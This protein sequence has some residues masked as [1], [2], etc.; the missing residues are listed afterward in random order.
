VKKQHK[1]LIGVVIGALVLGGI[2]GGAAL[3]APR[4]NALAGN[5][6]AA[7]YA[8]WGCP[9]LNGDY[10]TV[11]ALLGM[12]PEQIR[13]ELQQGK[14]LVEMA[15]AKGITEDQLVT[16]ILE[17]MKQFME[18]QVTAG[19]WT[20]AQKQAHLEQ[21]EEHVRQTVEAKGGAANGYANGF[22]C[23]GGMMGG[24]GNGGAG[25]GTFR[26]GMMGR[27]Y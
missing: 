15:T 11:A 1:I 18:Q 12:T 25:T 7:D 6:T 9:M 10:T 17:P 23:G 19:R 24:F 8:A 20:E 4:T 3:A 26:G 13:A 27:S 16:T 22:G 14:T 5:P 2:F 21:A